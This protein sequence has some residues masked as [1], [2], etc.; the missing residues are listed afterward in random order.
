MMRLLTLISNSEQYRKHPELQN[1]NA[2]DHSP[3]NKDSL[4]LLTMIFFDHQKQVLILENRDI[5]QK[6]SL[7][8]VWNIQAISKCLRM[9][10]QDKS[11][12]SHHKQQRL[13]KMFHS[14]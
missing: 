14:N 11:M 1:H 9:N 5:A 10:S 12:K 4:P 2:M 6:D 7:D 13:H 8:L 3:T